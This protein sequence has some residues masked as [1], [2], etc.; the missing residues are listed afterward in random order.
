MGAIE[1]YQSNAITTQ[2]RGGLIVMLYD[3]A[4][5][6][7]R[8]AI[9]ALEAGNLSAK[10]EYVAKATDI[11]VELNSVL[12]MDEGGEIASDLRRL[13]EFMIEHLTKAHIKN[14]PEMFGEV[15]SLL[16]DLNQGW[17]A[18]VD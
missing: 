1:A 13:Y 8:Q 17:K 14:D 7:I 4:I 18:I 12:D 16:D 5:R 9:I 2:S 11:I 15:I 6:S 3:G 10:G